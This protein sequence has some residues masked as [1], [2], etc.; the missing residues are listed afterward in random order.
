MSKTGGVQDL[1]I[2]K[3]M[4]QDVWENIPAIIDNFAPL[5]EKSLYKTIRDRRR[6]IL[7]ENPTPTKNT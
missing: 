3:D 4:R 1:I 7:I 5:L 6:R 2:P